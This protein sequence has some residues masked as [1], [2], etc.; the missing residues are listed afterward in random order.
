MAEHQFQLLASDLD[1]TILQ[2]DEHLSERVKGA[3]AEIQDRGLHFVLATGRSFQ[4]AQPYAELLNVALPLICYQ[5]GLIRDL[6]AGNTLYQAAVPH[7]LVEETAELSRERGWELL[8]YTAEEILV[9]EYRFPKELYYQKL[10]PTVRKVDDLNLSGGDEVVKLT[11][12]GMPNLIPAIE[13]DMRQRF[14]GR[15]EVFVSHPM[16]VEASPLGVSKGRALA[17][18]A[19]YLGVAQEQVMAIGDHDND[20]PMLTWAGFGVAMGN[21]SPGCRGAADWIAPAIE[22]D[23]CA[24]A[25][26]RFLLNCDCMQKDGL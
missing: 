12:L 25:I 18:L 3:I 5:G 4:S 11:I 20:A 6:G 19:K 16:F 24:V 8:L 14:A 21:A 15:M 26:E 1:G 2:H 17:W 7:N 10:G 22:D 9:A 13:A 23:G